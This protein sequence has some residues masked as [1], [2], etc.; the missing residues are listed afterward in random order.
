MKKAKII[1]VFI[2]GAALSSAVFGALKD[3]RRNAE[4]RIFVREIDSVN[5]CT[6]SVYNYSLSAMYTGQ[7][8]VM[9]VYAT[10][11]SGECQ[12]Y[13]EVYLCN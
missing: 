11:V 10:L 5:L 7:S 2:F 1:L 8:P 13:Y 12:T 6:M 4:C 3:T 9:T